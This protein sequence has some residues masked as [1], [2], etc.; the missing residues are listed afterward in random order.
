MRHG[1]SWITV[2]GIR[3]TGLTAS[4]GIASH[5][6][7]LCEEVQSEQ[8]G[9]DRSSSNGEAVVTASTARLPDVSELVASFKE[10]GDG[11]VVFGEAEGFGAHYVTHPLTREGFA[12][13]AVAS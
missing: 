11:T 2:G 4:L 10:R 3:S 12:R 8:E 13:L 6:G 9:G 1:G 5:V 7:R